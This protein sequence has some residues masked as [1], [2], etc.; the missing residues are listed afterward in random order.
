MAVESWFCK[1]E[2]TFDVNTEPSKTR[3]EGDAQVDFAHRT[4]YEGLYT[5]LSAAF[6][7]DDGISWYLSAYPNGEVARHSGVVTKKKAQP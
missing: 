3:Y 4:Y 1:I 2:F 6:P 7:G 5:R